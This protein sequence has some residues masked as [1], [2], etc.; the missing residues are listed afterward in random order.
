M[1]YYAECLYGNEK[2]EDSIKICDEALEELYGTSKVANRARIF[3]LRA[4]ARERKGL[5]DEEEKQECLR[6]YLT[7]YTVI[8]FYEGEEEAKELKKNIKEKYGWQ[9]ID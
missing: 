6:D 8:S 1:Q 4:K 7:A 5:K 2:Y 9:F 3:I